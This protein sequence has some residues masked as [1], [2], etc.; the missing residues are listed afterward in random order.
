MDADLLKAFLAVAELRGFSSAGKQLNLTQSAVSLQIKRLEEQIGVSLFSRTS[1]SVTL[2]EAGTTLVPFA[3]RMLRLKG[4]AEEAMIK[5]ATT[6]QARI[7]LTDEQAVAYLPHLLPAFTQAYPEIALEI[8][9]DESPQLVEQVHDGLLDL[10]MT[11]HYP[12]SNGGMV[13]GYENLYW[14]AANDFS[15]FS[16]DLI[17][18]AVN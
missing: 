9:C 4:E 17:P 18:L 16:D 1:R 14:I 3:Q 8:V 15:F 10:A 11:I 13:I 5:S 7:G 2:T 12:G 6:R